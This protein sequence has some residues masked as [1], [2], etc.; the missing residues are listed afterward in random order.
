VALSD[1]CGK[2]IWHREFLVAQGMNP[3]PARVNQDNMS[4][5]SLIKNGAST[6]DRTRHVAIRYFWVKDRISAKEIEVIYCPTEN[7]IA[8]I[9]TKPLV[10]EQFIKL[11]NLLLNWIF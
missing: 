9:L 11:R 5:M 6:S 7:M 4:T 3:P 10:G 1:M 8:D 2:V